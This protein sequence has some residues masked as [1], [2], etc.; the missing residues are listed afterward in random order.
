MRTTWIA[1]VLMVAFGAWAASQ[2]PFPAPSKTA[3][4]NSDISNKGNDHSLEKWWSIVVPGLTL[5]L[6]GAQVWIYWRQRELM[7]KQ[8][9]I[10]QSGLEMERPYVYAAVSKSGLTIVPSRNRQGSELERSTLELCIYNIGRTPANLTRLEHA[11]STAQHGGIATAI[12][13]AVV[14]GRELPVGTIAVNGDPFFE[15]TNMRL[16]FFNEEIDIVESK[17]SVWVV[18]FVRYADIFGGHHINGFAL[19]FDPVGGRFVRRGGEKY[20]YARD[21]DPSSI[22]PGS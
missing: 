13:P 1:L 18:G 5:L 12:D 14:G 7:A 22:P 16:E 17:Q 20:N 19:V 15:S 10:M 21:E 6:L 2:P 4:V 9:G 3:Q 11:L 8:A